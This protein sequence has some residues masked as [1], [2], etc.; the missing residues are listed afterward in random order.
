MPKLHLSGLRSRISAILIAC[1]CVGFTFLTGCEKASVEVEDANSAFS[2]TIVLK[3]AYE[4]KPGEPIDIGLQ[5]WKREL[6]DRSFGTMTLELYPDSSLGNKDQI[7]KRIASGENI[8]TI[9]DGAFFYSLGQPEMGIVFGPYL[10]HNWDEAFNI[11]KSIW[12]Q[13]QSLELAKRTGIKLISVEWAY[14]VRHLLTKK[15]IKTI[16]DLRGLKIRVPSNTIQE[17][18]FAVFGAEPVKMPLSEV[19]SALMSGKI[20]GLENPITTL[21]NG[22][23]HRQAKYLTLTAHV[24]NVANIVMS[25][26][27]WLALNASQ[28]R[29]LVDSCNRAAK[30]YDVVTAADELTVLKKMKD[31]GVIVEEPSQSLLSSLREYSTNFYSLPDFKWPKGLY[32]NLMKIKTRANNKNIDLMTHSAILNVSYSAPEDLQQAA[33]KAGMDLSSYDTNNEHPSISGEVYYIPVADDVPPVVLNENP[34]K[35]TNPIWDPAK[36]GRKFQEPNV[37]I[38]AP[39]GKFAKPG[40]PKFVIFKG[41]AVSAPAQAPAA[42]SAAKAAAQ[43][44]ASAQATSTAQ[45]TQAAPAQAQGQAQAPAAARSANQE[46]A[47]PDANAQP[48]TPIITRPAPGLNM[49][50]PAPGL[51]MAPQAN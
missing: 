44:A 33:N 34:P 38:V 42:Q 51:N 30:F 40:Q 25:Q 5:R 45:P 4:N 15:P 31:E 46:A 29:M 21:Y 1:A 24:Y 41:K 23:F 11:S 28:Q 22:G 43:T 12:Y 20:D 50:R 49:A 13:K 26:K 19:N 32:A 10:A 6:E 7:L 8:I 27:Q 47:A 14:G 36:Q 3:V 17:K 37:P 18:T 35:D 16:E 48:A 9:A 2:P 39:L